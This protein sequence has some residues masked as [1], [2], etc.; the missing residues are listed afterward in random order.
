MRMIKKLIKLVTDKKYRFEVLDRRGAFNGVSD[1]R[2]L[3]KKYKVTFGK[4]LDLNNPITYNEKLQWLKLYNRKP[5]YTTMVDKYES[6]AYVSGIVGGKYVIPALGVWDRFED[7]DFD[8][9]PDRFVLK[10]THDSGGLVI[11]RDKSDFDRE[12]ARKKIERCQARNYYLKSREWPY[13]DVKPR[14]MAE[15]YISG[16]NEGAASTHA[17]SDAVSCD[18]LQAKHGLLDYKF[19][20]FNGKVRALFLDIGVIGKGTEHAEEYYRNVYDE[21]GVLLP[22]KETRDNY[23]ES[24]VLP[25]NLDEMI[26]IA[27][28]LSEGT[29]HLRVDLYRLNSGEIKVGEMTFFHGSG[30]SNFFIPEEWNKIFGDWIDLT[31]VK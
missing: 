24:I 8:A 22:V 26:K 20:C 7:I 27:E 9:L 2:Y 23:P 21:N 4:S 10:C 16:L 11:V 29:P 6:K 15:D 30:F 1:E 12:S 18:E 25:S 13:K 14:I 5:L 31:S 17:P 28:A 19:M 3:K